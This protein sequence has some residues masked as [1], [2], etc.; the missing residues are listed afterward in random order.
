MWL[1]LHA[2]ATALSLAQLLFFQSVCLTTGCIYHLYKDTRKE[3]CIDAQKRDDFCWFT[4][5]AVQITA[6]QTKQCPG[7]SQSQMS[8]PSSQSLK[9]LVLLPDPVQFVRCSGEKE[10][11]SHGECAISLNVPLAYRVLAPLW[12]RTLSCPGNVA[13]HLQGSRVH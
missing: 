12:K 13:L 3:Q 4:P 7:V 11:G 2:K 9:T 8:Q 6:V 10:G 1:A 5:M